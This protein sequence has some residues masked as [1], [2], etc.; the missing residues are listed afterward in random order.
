MY[1][2]GYPTLLRVR[3]EAVRASDGVVHVQ[4]TRAR[5]GHI[6]CR[7]GVSRLPPTRGLHADPGPEVRLVLLFDVVPGIGG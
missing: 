2:Q 7:E 6:K 3:V 5:H 1:L 4:G